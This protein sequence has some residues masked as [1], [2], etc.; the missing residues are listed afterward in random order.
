[1]KKL[2]FLFTVS[3]ILSCC[4]NDDDN[5]TE[6]L[7]PAT[8]TGAGTFAC[9][10]NG[11]SFIDTS[12]GYF[13]CFYQFNNGE[14][15]FG[16]QGNDRVG[17]LISVDIGTYKKEVFENETY[18]LLDNIDGNAWAG[19]SFNPNSNSQEFSSTNLQY[20][21]E[22]KITKLDFTNNIVSGTF[23]FDVENPYTGEIVEIR[24]G[25]FDTLFTQ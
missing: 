2:I 25:R 22:F 8:Q 6:T 15:Y 7:P 12:G 13:N 11:Q 1:M 16:I 20:T 9:K 24:D 18:Q 3:L 23:W 17:S 21:G 4:S 5:N 19:S 14:Y 10:V